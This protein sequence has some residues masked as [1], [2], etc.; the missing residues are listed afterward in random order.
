[1]GLYQ[2]LPTL[3]TRAAVI[4]G[5]DAT[6]IS[7]PPALDAVTDSVTQAFSPS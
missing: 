1:L 3:I 2:A 4:A 6:R 5:V 7:F